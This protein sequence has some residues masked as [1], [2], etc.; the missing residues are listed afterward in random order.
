M[1]FVGVALHIE[2]A[3][4]VAAVAGHRKFILLRG[5]RAW[6]DGHAEDMHVGED[7]SFICMQA[8]FCSAIGIHRALVEAVRLFARHQ[9]EGPPQE[10]LLAKVQSIFPAVDVPNDV[11]PLGPAVHRG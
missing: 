3:A 8:F 7:G 4:A 6:V 10:G 1:D 9:L 5:I 2:E 11:L